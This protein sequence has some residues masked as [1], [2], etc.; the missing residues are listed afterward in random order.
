MIK[1]H[2]ITN[3]IVLKEFNIHSIYLW[4]NKN[5]SQFTIFKF[6]IINFLIIILLNHFDI[7]LLD[8]YKFRSHFI[9]FYINFTKSNILLLYSIININFIMMIIDFKIILIIENTNFKVLNINN[10]NFLILIPILLF[11]FLM[12]QVL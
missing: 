5:F 12:N 8:P 1:F 2:S 9:S 6:L 3:C 10:L 11:F 4:I 7:S